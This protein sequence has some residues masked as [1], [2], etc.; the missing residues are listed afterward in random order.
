MSIRNIPL[1]I[2]LVI[3]VPSVHAST[4][5]YEDAPLSKIVKKLR[6]DDHDIYSLQGPDI[7]PSIQDGL[8]SAAESITTHLNFLGTLA[9][10]YTSM[11]NPKDKRL[12]YYQ[13]SGEKL[14]F[15]YRCKMT[16]QYISQIM[17]SIQDAAMVIDAQQL[18]SDIRQSCDLVRKWQG[19]TP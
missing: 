15:G 6:V 3:I 9:S 5:K 12:V 13:L 19:I 17:G 18:R 2:S 11:G 4:F 14:L 1:L 8:S 10:L 16:D 7:V